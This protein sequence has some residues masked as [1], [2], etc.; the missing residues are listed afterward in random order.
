MTEAV[1]SLT[2]VAGMTAAICASLGVSRAT[3]QRRRACLTAPPAAGRLRPSMG[4][5]RNDAQL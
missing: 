4:R 3:V 1:V 5:F 2:P